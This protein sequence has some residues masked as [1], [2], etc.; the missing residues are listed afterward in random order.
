MSIEKI[1]ADNLEYFTLVTHPDR[2]FASSSTGL[3]GA[4]NLFAR[5]SS[6]EK[7]VHP[8]SMFTESLFRDVDIDAVRKIAVNNTA[9]NIYPDIFSYVSAV[10]NQ[11]FSIRLRQQQEIIRFTPT[12][13]FSSNT[14]R[15]NN[16]RTMLMPHYRSV[17][18]RSQWNFANYHCLNFFTS[19][20]VPEDSAL[21]YPNSKSLGTT[22]NITGSIYQISGA[23]SFDFYIKPKYSIT[24]QSLQYKPGSIMHL[25][26]SYALSLHTGSLKDINGLSSGFR[27]ALALSSSANT[28]PS[29]LTTSTPMTFFSSDNSLTKDEWQ[30]VTV[31][32]GGENYNNGS[33]SIVING[34]ID[35]NFTITQSLGLGFYSGSDDPSVLVIGNYYEGTNSSVNAMSRFFAED[36]S[37][38]EGLL[39]LETTAGV[40][41]P[42]TSSFSHPLNAE[43]HE[44]KLYDKYLTIP[45]TLIL[46][47]SGP[48][49]LNN[50]KFY[51]PPFFTQESP[52]RQ[53]LDGS[54]GVLVT[55]FFAENSTTETPFANKMAFSVGGHYVNLENYTR[56]FANGLYPRLW[57]LSGSE[58]TPPSTTVL[59]ANEFLY[60]TGSIRKRLYTILPCDNGIFYPNFN[61]L[62]PLSGSKFVNDMNNRELGVVTLNNIISG[63]FASKAI[64]SSGSILD[65]IFGAQADNLGALPGDSLAILHNLRDNSSNQVTFFDISNL[66]YG[67]K[68]RPGTFKMANMAITQSGGALNIQIKDDGY[69]NL[70]RADASGSLATWASIGN[71]FYDEGLVVLKHPNLFFFGENQF[72]VS[73]KGE[74]NL[75]VFTVNAFAKAM[76]ETT[77]SNPSF[78]DF[79]VND[80]ANNNDEKAVYLTQV[81]IMDENLNVIIRSQLAAPFMKKSSDKILFKTKIDY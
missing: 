48:T 44:L 64:T 14:L 38:R 35:T 37:I 10:H 2:T 65:N 43:I 66:F 69:G 72:D 45:E 52:F 22:G 9:S 39:E 70:Y 11:P 77:S 47:A 19:S 30:H 53:T 74:Q 18:P 33:G 12:F 46:S 4:V 42:T 5:R 41:A 51:L 28:T 75:H 73:F 49:N 76:H 50:L 17:Y 26:N 68:I 56:D 58:F 25:T 78:Q 55:P 54:G 24:S 3:T 59:S 32:W 29:N 62:A 63:P 7:E 23:F 60:M 8:L 15:K 57:N 61:L 80:L 79:T 20:A 71:I 40:N 34:N 67:N 27:V 1:S 36:T 16:V 81:L 13:H 6:F 31:R 21:L